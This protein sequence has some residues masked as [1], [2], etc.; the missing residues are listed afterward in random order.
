MQKYPQEFFSD[1]HAEDP[2]ITVEEAA[3]AAS[4]SASSAG[5]RPGKEWYCPHHS[6]KIRRQRERAKLVAEGKDT[7]ELDDEILLETERVVPITAL[8]PA[9]KLVGVVPP[10]QGRSKR[11]YIPVDLADQ[12]ERAAESK[13]AEKQLKVKIE[14]LDAEEKVDATRRKRKAEIDAD[15]ESVDSSN[16]SDSDSSRQSRKRLRKVRAVAVASISC[17]DARF[18]FYS[19]RT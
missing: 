19:P 9:H 14:E 10:R 2:D 16:S 6:T 11:V 4:S 7:T 15:I 3:A 13:E 1:E 12:D 8:L 5:E 17:A 18:I